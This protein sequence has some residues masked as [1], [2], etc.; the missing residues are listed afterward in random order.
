MKRFQKVLCVL[1]ALALMSIIPAAA[2]AVNPNTQSKT[3]S[4]T[5]GSMTVTYSVRLTISNPN[6][7]ATVGMSVTPTT[8]PTYKCTK[9]TV[10]PKSGSPRDMANIL[11]ST[12][13]SSA[14][15]TIGVGYYNTT[16]AVTAYMSASTVGR[17]SST[18]TLT[19]S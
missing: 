11:N 16:A 17:G 15:T 12:G 8:T 5:D 6:D 4:G 18:C 19:A 10:T 7:K 1:M 14:S 3:S 2:F 13:K 9:L